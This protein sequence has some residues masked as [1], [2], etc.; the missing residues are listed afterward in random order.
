MVTSP[1]P[2]MGVVSWPDKCRLSSSW[3]SRTSL[4][5]L[6]FHC[7]HVCLSQGS[8]QPCHPHP[9]KSPEARSTNQA[10]CRLPTLVKQEP[11]VSLG[12]ITKT[13]EIDQ[14]CLTTHWKCLEWGNWG[15]GYMPATGSERDKA[16]HPILALGGCCVSQAVAVS[17]ARQLRGQPKGH[18]ALSSFPGSWMEQL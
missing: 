14:Q 5:V 11:D 18:R 16:A 10:P 4:W 6:P 3:I 1:Q 15:R 13:A 9:K 2:C 8:A 12:S 17:L 7:T